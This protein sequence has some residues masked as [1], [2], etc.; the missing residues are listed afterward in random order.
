MSA[1]QRTRD[2]LKE[3]PGF[4]RASTIQE[5]LADTNVTILVHSDFFQ[6][7]TIYMIYNSVSGAPQDLKVLLMRAMASKITE[8]GIAPSLSFGW[9]SFSGRSWKASFLV[10]SYRP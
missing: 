4:S 5:V 10:K 7:I 6:S 9:M 8:N 2:R 3:E 1:K